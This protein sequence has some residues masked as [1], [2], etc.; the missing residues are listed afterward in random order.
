MFSSTK[1]LLKIVNAVRD[2]QES[3]HQEIDKRLDTIEK[4]LIVQETNLQLHMKRSDNLEKLVEGIREKDIEPVKKH[5]NMVE[6]S[7]KLIG[8]IGLIVSILTGLFKLFG[9]I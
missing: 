4:V 7:L 3:N 1:E 9:T 8:L 2:K 6:G 5:V